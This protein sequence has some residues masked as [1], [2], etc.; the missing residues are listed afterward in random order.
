MTERALRVVIIGSSRHPVAEPFAG[1]LEAQVWHLARTLSRRGHDVTLF[2]S[3]GSD[4]SVARRELQ[5]Q[6]IELSEYARRDVSMPPG[7]W[8]DEHHAY[9][10]LML[11]LADNRN[12][13][14]DIVQNHSLHHLPIALS[15]TLTAPMLTTLHTPPTPWLESALRIESEFRPPLAAV[16]EYT[17]GQ[18]YEVSPDV[19]V[20]PNGVDLAGWPMGEGGSDAIWFGRLVP[21]KGPHIAIEAARA[22]GRRLSLAGP[23]ADLAYFEAAIA[24]RLDAEVRYLGHLRQAELARVVGGSAVT[25]VTPCWDEPFGL[26]VAESLAC[27]TPVA[28]F[29]RGGIPEVVDSSCGTL[30]VADDIAGLGDAINLAAHLPRADCRRRAEDRWSVERMTDRYEAEYERLLTAS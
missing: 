18:W 11:E 13:S 23:I 8:L 26:V 1:G 17:A 14:Y 7:L 10:S 27:G 25:V 12:S 3:P 19:V 20:V 29:A 30:A 15:R 6:R 28:A 4:L 21:E 22:A 5:M 16:S 2:A 24:P 9:L